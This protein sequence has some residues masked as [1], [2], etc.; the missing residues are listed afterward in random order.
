MR[1]FVMWEIFNEK[2]RVMDFV[3]DLEGWLRNRYENFHF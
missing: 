2:V 3:G 1:R